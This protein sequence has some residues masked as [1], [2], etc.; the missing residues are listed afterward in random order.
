MELFRT[1]ALAHLASS[2][3]PAV[4]ASR[5]PRPTLAAFRSHGLSPCFRY[6]SAVRPLAGLRSPFRAL[7][8][9]IASPAA[10]RGRCEFSRGHACVFRTVP[11]ANTLVR[12]VNE[13]AFA[14]VVRARPC[15]LFG[16]PV[17]HRMAPID[18]GPVLLLRP[19]GFRLTADTLPSQTFAWASEGITPA[20]WIWRSSFERQRDLN[21]PDSC[22]ARRTL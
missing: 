10:S 8:Y 9:R 15:P 22:A 14:P 1:T 12:E 17:H 11:S 2:F 6:Y 19:F 13:I 16:R 4:F 20:S 7:T 3:S 5:L 21:P 18:Y